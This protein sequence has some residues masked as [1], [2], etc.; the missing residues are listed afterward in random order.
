MK[1]LLIALNARYTHSSLAIAYL[2]R[3]CSHENWRL[4][5]KEFTINEK[6]SSIIGEIF[7]MKPA[8]LGISC[9]IWNITMVEE[10]IRDYKKIDPGC[11]IIL[12][13]PEVSQDAVQVLL[14]NPGADVVV[15]GEGEIVLKQVLASIH[16]N[17][18]LAGIRGIIY[19]R[20]GELQSGG[21]A[22]LI[23][24]LA[25]VPSP[26]QGDMSFYDHKV[27]YYE[28]SR[29]CPFNCGYCLSSTIKGVRYFPLERVKGELEYLIGRKVTKI[30]FVDRTFNSDEKRALEIMQ[31]ILN[32]VGEGAATSFHFEICADIISEVML[33]FLDQIPPGLFDF[34]I[35]VQST[36]PETLKAINRHANWDKLQKAVRRI[37][38][39]RNIHIHI[40]LIAG[41][42]YETYQRF[43][44]SF[45]DVYVLGPD[46]IQLGF[47]K[48]L[49]GSQIHKE[50]EKYQYIFQSKAPYQIM[51]NRFMSYQDIIDLKDIEALVGIYY[52]SGSFVNSIKYIVDKVFFQNAFDFFEK[53]ATFWRQKHYFDKSYKKEQ[54]YLLLM[55]YITA[56][57]PFYQQMINELLK[58]DYLLNNRTCRVP[59]GLKRYRLDEAALLINKTLKQTDFIE[60]NQ[61]I[62]LGRTLR[63]IKKYCHLEYLK[64]NPDELDEIAE[65][66]PVIFFYHPVLNKCTGTM[67]LFDNRFEAV[68]PGI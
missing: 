36:C 26:Y 50:K 22:P 34:E 48:L 15:M 65:P 40:D 23:S 45:N 1:V 20:Q 37:K 28:T 21:E 39:N 43:G 64:M 51:E 53:F 3:A 60:L 29:G 42:P 7:R 27:I 10:L 11:I 41:L 33:E 58:Y 52:N 63:E 5:H 54:Y 47:L 56:E 44:Q 18:G 67:L 55:N 16:G 30:K 31:F 2:S 35:G 9:Y 19:R 66:I 24:D 4:E 62:L 61:P 59:E 12:G 14:D 25:L 57:H 68:L 6:V 32:Q 49:K 46:V 8:V 13:G 38:F 17:Q